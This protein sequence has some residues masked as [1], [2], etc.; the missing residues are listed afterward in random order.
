MDRGKSFPMIPSDD[1]YSELDG[2]FEIDVFPDFP[3]AHN[4]L[5]LAGPAEIGVLATAVDACAATSA[6]AA[7]LG[8]DLLLVHHGMLWGAGPR[9]VGP[10]FRTVAPLIETGCALYSIHLPLDAH[11][12][13]GN[14]ILL[15]QRLAMPSPEPFGPYEGRQIGYVGEV[16]TTDV[17]AAEAA[18]GL[19]LEEAVAPPGPVRRIAVVSGSGASFASAALDAGADVL[20]TGEIKHHDRVACRDLGLGVWAGG[21]YA[22]ETLGVH[23]LG[24]H[25]AETHGFE[26]HFIDLPTGG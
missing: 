9:I 5:Q 19:T 10:Y 23:A 17:T 8:A 20:L 6:R 22:T 15:C 3:P 24:E 11:P 12:V 13:F 2:T 25:L 14:N 1:L 7:E 16:E 18:L 4:G 26:H 21:H